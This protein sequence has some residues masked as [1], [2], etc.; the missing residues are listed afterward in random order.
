MIIRQQGGVTVTRSLALLGAIILILGVSSCSNIVKEEASTS[1]SNLGELKLSLNVKKYTLSNGLRVLIV[2]NHRLPIYSYYTF[3]DVGGRFEGPGTTGATHFLEHMMFKG[4]KKYGPGK[5]D[6]LIESNGGSTNAYTTFDSTVY[7]QSMPAHTIDTIIDLEADRMENLLLEKVAF[8]KER[9]VVLEERKYRY[10][11]SSKGKLYLTMMQEMFKGTPYGLS[12]I[13]SVEDLIT[14]NRDQMF[15][16]FKKFYTPDNAII[17]VVGDVDSGDVISQIKKKFGDLERSSKEI[18][19][20]KKEKDKDELYV[21]NPSFGSH[22]KVYGNTKTPTFMMAYRG[23][24]LGTRKAYVMDILSSI[25]GV[26]GSSYFNQKYVKNKRPIL[27]SVSV[28]NYN[29]QKNGVFFI[30][31]E[32]GRNVKL[33]NVR[34]TLVKDTRSLCEKA[35]DDR[36]VQKTKNQFLVMYYGE[37]QNNSGVASFIGATEKFYGDY[38]HYQKELEIYDSIT[39]DEVKKTCKEVFAGNKQVFVSVWDKHK[40]AKGK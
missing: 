14:L 12:V 7:Y 9:D 23:E 17:V 32:L 6:T 8:D 21:A 30:S 20:L 16:F 19:E 35:I 34:R 29:L 1:G 28:S 5:F 27:N 38:K 3:Y 24:P 22:K 4:A 39:T 40:K 10:E 26:G 13:G 18:Q 36:G 2:E 37:I 33:E 15:D 31:G 25:L 11:N